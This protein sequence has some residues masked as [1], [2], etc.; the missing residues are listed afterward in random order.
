MLK[1]LDRTSKRRFQRAISPLQLRFTRFE[2]SQS[3][4][5]YRKR[6]ISRDRKTLWWIMMLRNWSKNFSMNFSRSAFFARRRINSAAVF[7][8]TQIKSRLMARSDVTSYLV[9]QHLRKTSATWD[10]TEKQTLRSVWNTN[11]WINCRVSRNGI[12]RDNF[13]LDSTVQ[14]FI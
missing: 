3:T 12:G 7:K 10:K 6:K 5:A 1:R 2:G 4:K 14:F 11:Y 9:A 8:V 13:K